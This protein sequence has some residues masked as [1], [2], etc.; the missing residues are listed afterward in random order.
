MGRFDGPITFAVLMGA[1]AKGEGDRY[2]SRQGL[3]FEIWL[4]LLQNE[5]S[6][7]QF[8]RIHKSTDLVVLICAQPLDRKTIAQAPVVPLLAF[9][10]F[11]TTGQALRT[12]ASRPAHRS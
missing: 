1:E 7:T 6:I 4:E 3:I 10:L 5:A 12:S 9:A 2:R 8:R 11:S